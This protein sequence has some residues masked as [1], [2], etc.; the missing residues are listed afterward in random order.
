MLRTFLLLLSPINRCALVWFC[1]VFV[2]TFMWTDSHEYAT[3]CCSVFGCIRKNC[4][5]GFYFGHEFVWLALRDM[6][7]VFIATALSARLSYENV[8]YDVK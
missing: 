2:R 5:R 4:A 1:Q 6:E 8:S 3:K 7:K